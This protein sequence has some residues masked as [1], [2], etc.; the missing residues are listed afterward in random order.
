MNYGSVLGQFSNS[1]LYEKNS[2]NSLDVYR[3]QFGKADNGETAEIWTDDKG[4]FIFAN[5][6]KSTW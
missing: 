2:S 4:L 5:F 1:K 3:G 6:Y